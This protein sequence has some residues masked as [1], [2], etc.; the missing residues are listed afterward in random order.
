MLTAKKISKSRYCEVNELQ[1]LKYMNK[2]QFSLD[3]HPFIE[4]NKLLKILG[5]CASGGEAKTLIAAGRIKLDG[6][7]ELRIRCKI[8]Q[9]QVVEIGEGSVEVT[10]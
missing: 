7:V 10:A 9:G 5:L 8:R 3:G 4:L 6:E 2:K 1:A